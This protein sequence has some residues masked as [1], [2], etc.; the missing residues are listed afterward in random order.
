M[1]VHLE[2][3]HQVPGLLNLLLFRLTHFQTT[4]ADLCLSFISS[5][6]FKNL[7]NAGLLILDTSISHFECL[8]S[9]G[10]LR[11]QNV[12]FY[13]EVLDFEKHFHVAVKSVLTRQ[14]GGFERIR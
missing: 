10:H 13:Y 5:K 14:E 7:V 9:L 3:R 12:V 8:L 11:Y 6:T 4:N 1:L 2:I